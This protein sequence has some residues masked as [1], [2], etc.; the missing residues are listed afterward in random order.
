M[1][2]QDAL[3]VLRHLA[4][5]F[6]FLLSLPYGLP[7]SVSLIFSRVI[8]ES[9]FMQQQRQIHMITNVCRSFVAQ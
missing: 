5:I 2:K 3:A 6:L 8:T 1:A 9:K 7:A 4:D